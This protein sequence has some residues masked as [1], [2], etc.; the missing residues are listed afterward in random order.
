MPPLK[1][2]V[3][4]R[5]DARGLPLFGVCGVRWERG[6]R[7]GC[8]ELELLEEELFCLLCCFRLELFEVP[9]DLRPFSVGVAISAAMAPG[10]FFR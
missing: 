7:G 2:M 3:G 6:E 1:R 8:C 9:P 5:E 10:Q 4:L